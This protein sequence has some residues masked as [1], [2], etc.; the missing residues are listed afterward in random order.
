M[1]EVVN[2]KDIPW[3]NGDSGPKY[4]F[5][6]PKM[7]GGLI[8]YK[9]G[10]RLGKHSHEEIDECFLVLEGAPTFILGDETRLMKPG[11]AFCVPAK[12]AHDIINETSEDCKI[13]FMKAPYIPGDKVKHD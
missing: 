10:Q 8:L 11:D 3:R 2:E 4:L 9:P 6:G 5:K 12:V 1:V 7:D 13:F